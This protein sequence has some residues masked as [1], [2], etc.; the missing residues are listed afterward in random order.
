MYKKINLYHSVLV[1]ATVSQFVSLSLLS[2]FSYGSE[3]WMHHYLTAVWLPL[4]AELRYASDL[5]TAA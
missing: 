5:V 3:C 1:T 2:Y 4:G